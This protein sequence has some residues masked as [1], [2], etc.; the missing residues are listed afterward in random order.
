MSDL[1]AVK[2]RLA[3]GGAALFLSLL[4]G[5]CGSTPSEKPAPPKLV[6]LK[7]VDPKTRT[8][9]AVL[10]QLNRAQADWQIFT[11]DLPD[12]E[13]KAKLEKV[14]RYLRDLS[15][16]H[17]NELLR[18]LVTGSENFRTIAAFAVGWPRHPEAVQPLINALRDPSPSVV[19]NACLGLYVL[20]LPEIPP[21]PLGEVALHHTDPDARCNAA[22]ALS[23]L[24]SL[25]GKA[26]EVRPF[27][28]KLLKSEDARVRVHALRGFL[29]ISRTEDLPYLLPLL[30]DP[31]PLVR[32]AAVLA[33]GHVGGP[34][35]VAPILA[36]LTPGETNENVRLYARKVLQ[37]LA[38]GR[39]AGYDVE[40][41][42][43]IFADVL[44]PSLKR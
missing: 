8:I 12:A 13:A 33:V 21:G 5:G 10:L 24:A 35:V 40:A 6:P 20:K 3:P 38:G 41:W 2:T 44:R 34:K 14:E 7:A 37:R 4:L 11:K 25:P 32:S 27:L 23:A 30:K 18:V 26:D 1:S 43:K 28:K 42:K 39:D 29:R 16:R 31:V 17:L 15:S 36:L 9:Q 19:C 22:L